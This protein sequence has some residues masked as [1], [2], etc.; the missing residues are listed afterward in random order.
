MAL[1]TLTGQQ[2]AVKTG[3][4]RWKYC[5]FKGED[6]GGA[7]GGLQGACDGHACAAV[8][9]LAGTLPAWPCGMQRGLGHPACSAARWGSAL[10]LHSGQVCHTFTELQVVLGVSTYTY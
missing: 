1:S 3:T 2:A 8:L 4:F 5:L 6:T 7:V 9:L 10:L